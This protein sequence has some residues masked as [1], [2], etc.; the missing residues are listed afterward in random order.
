MTGII[1][2]PYALNF[3]DPRG[4]GNGN[5]TTANEITLEVTRVVIAISVFAVGVELPKV[6]QA[7][8]HPL[9]SVLLESVLSYLA[10]RPT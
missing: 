5:D 9:F 3:F 10:I 1:I 7:S 6:C 2:G 8:L 4:W